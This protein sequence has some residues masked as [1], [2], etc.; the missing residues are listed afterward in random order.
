M[1]KNE[2]LYKAE[3]KGSKQSERI[4]EE[5][6]KQK[7][8]QRA[9]R[10]RVILREKERQGEGQREENLDIL[11]DLGREMHIHRRASGRDLSIFLSYQE[12]DLKG[13]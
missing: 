1:T 3:E 5:K 9:Q 12:K 4:L 11:R 7:R 2:I 10:Y 8:D 6:K 13:I